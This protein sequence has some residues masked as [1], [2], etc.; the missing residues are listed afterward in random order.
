[1]PIP[2]VGICSGWLCI[3][4]WYSEYSDM[5]AP[6]VAQVVQ[7]IDCF[8]LCRKSRSTESENLFS[9]SII[10]RLQ[11]NWNKYIWKVSPTETIVFIFKQ[12][13]V[14]P[15]S[16]SLPEPCHQHP[17]Y[18]HATVRSLSQKY[19]EFC[20]RVQ[21]KSHKWIGFIAPK[22]GVFGMIVSFLHRQLVGPWSEPSKLL[23]MPRPLKLNWQFSLRPSATAFNDV[24]PQFDGIQKRQ[25]TTAK[26]GWNI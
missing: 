8:N 22:C 11:M 1:M 23:I 3:G 16:Q 24:A 6:Q 21:S 14:W 19:F 18:Y 7:F 20:T 9:I 5:V 26:F 13:L 12:I 15:W 17:H 25:F 10:G 4:S 2:S